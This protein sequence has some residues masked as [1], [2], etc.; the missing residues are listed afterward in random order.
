LA[1]ATFPQFQVYPA[2]YPNYRRHLAETDQVEFDLPS[3]VPDHSLQCASLKL[4]M[5]TR[6]SLLADEIDDDNEAC[7]MALR[8]TQQFECVKLSHED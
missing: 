2:C 5:H 4:L 8:E 6:M 3:L 1:W 7:A